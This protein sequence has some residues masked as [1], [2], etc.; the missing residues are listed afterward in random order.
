MRRAKLLLGACFAA[1]L[2]APQPLPSPPASPSP[3]KTEMDLTKKRIELDVKQLFVETA[4]APRLAV[5]DV[6]NPWV[7]PGKVKWH[8]SFADARAA[9]VNSGKPVLLFQMMGRLDQQFT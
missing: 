4:P 5:I 6:D 8:K 7:E 9:A 3:V 1:V 2:V